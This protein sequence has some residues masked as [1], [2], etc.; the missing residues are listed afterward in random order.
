MAEQNVNVILKQEEKREEEIAVIS[1]STIFRKLKKYF[2]VWL[3]VAILVGGL[4][5]SASM[6][7]TT[8]S[9]NPVRAVVSFNYKGIEKGKNPDGTDFDWNTLKAPR[10]ISKALEECGM[11]PEL[12]EPVRQGMEIEGK[13]PEDAYQRL[14]TY[15]NVYENSSSGQLAAANA[16]LDVSWF[17]TQYNI[18]FKYR[19]AAITRTE[20][21]Q[22]LNAM[23]DAYRS[24]FYEEFGY[25]EALGVSLSAQNY[26]DYDYAEAVDLFRDSLKQLN[27]YVTSLANED[28]TRFRS[29][30]TG[31]TFADL[32]TAIN[33]IQNLDL[34]LI[35]SYLSVNNITKD[36]V[37]L[38][39][40]YEYRIEN[41]E[42]Q[43]ITDQETLDAIQDA[44]D[45]YEKDQVIIFSDSVGNTETTVSSEEYDKLINRRITA[46]ENLSE[47]KQSIAFYKQR[48]QTLKKNTIA[49]SEDKVERIEK[50]LEKVNKKLNEMI[51]L[52][53][54]TADDYYQ[55]VS[56]GNAYN[57]LVPAAYDA[58][59]T[60]K[61]GISKAVVPCVGAEA[62]IFIFYL[63]VSFVMALIEEM[64][65]KRMKMEAAAETDGD[66]PKNVAEEP[67]AKNTADKTADKPEK[68]KK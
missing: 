64:K 24:Y 6:F 58:A 27:H 47:T 45:A 8:T 52:V 53:E 20:A 59:T 5:A 2:A 66:E 55:N 17:S 51:E 49:N 30:A 14:N 39:A 3:M 54:K 19:E 56:L 38:Q 65:A 12:L 57:V 68:N 13:M 41:L 21:V 28:S 44:F 46:Q 60:V 61:H 63:G 40:Y 16:M 29:S 31:Y 35:S 48:L 36:K 43:Q 42:R 37:R 22:L 33:S 23:L 62:M 10:I 15:Q 34:D 25:N 18:T 11:N 4:I 7:F 67:T 50:D 26:K 1:F 32:K 9:S